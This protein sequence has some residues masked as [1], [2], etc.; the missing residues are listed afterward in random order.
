MKTR[1]KSPDFPVVN[2]PV[3]VELLHRA[4]DAWSAASDFRQRRERYKRYT[5]G[6]QWDDLITL[7]DSC[8][9]LFSIALRGWEH[10]AVVVPLVD[11]PDLFDEQF[12]PFTRG[13]PQ[14]PVAILMPD[15]T[16]RLYSMPS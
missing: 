13:C 16:V 15:R 12:N 1:Q 4:Y 7:P 8:R 11:N 14:R 10:S 9:R 5:Y 3:A 2:S 6:R